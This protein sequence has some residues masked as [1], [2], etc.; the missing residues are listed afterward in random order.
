M[1]STEGVARLNVTYPRHETPVTKLF[2][3]AAAMH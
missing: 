1:A 2:L 3:D